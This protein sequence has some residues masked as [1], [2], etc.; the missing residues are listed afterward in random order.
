M[1]DPTN[2]I[3]NGMNLPAPQ[4]SGANGESMNVVSKS[5]VTNLL[6]IIESDAKLAL[7]FC[8]VDQTFTGKSNVQNAK[9]NLATIQRVIQTIN[10]CSFD[11]IMTFEPRE[12]A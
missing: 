11:A 6:E 1:L 7:Q 10:D 4:R 8:E 2:G 3:T 5:L 12:T 9:N